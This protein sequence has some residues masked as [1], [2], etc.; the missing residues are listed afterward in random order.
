[1]DD[2]Q[3]FRVELLLPAEDH[4]VVAVA[5]E[6]DIYTAPQFEAALLH[7]IDE[8]ARRVVVDLTDVTFIDS[9]ALSVV[10]GAVKRLRSAGDGSLDIVYG[11]D[12][13]RRVFEITGL[14]SVLGMY[15]GSPAARS[16]A[17]PG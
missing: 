5:G 3:R 4:A 8:G 17:K 12:N 10:V 14:A 7:S 13:V 2:R 15:A 1:M 9:T 11:S 16:G 6:L